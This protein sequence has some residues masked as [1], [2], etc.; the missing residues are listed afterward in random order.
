MAQIV[1]VKV[2]PEDERTRLRGTAGSPLLLPEPGFLESGFG[3][4]R[5]S[6]ATWQSNIGERSNGKI[7]EL[8]IRLQNPTRRHL[9]GRHFALC[10]QIREGSISAPRE[11]RSFAQ[12]LIKGSDRGKK[13]IF[14]GFMYIMLIKIGARSQ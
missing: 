11:L 1:R 8:L 14:S 9:Q 13:L 4:R 3:T 10:E 6:E 7:S 2:G 5:L 12:A